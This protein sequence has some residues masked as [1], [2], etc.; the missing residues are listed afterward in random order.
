MAF[1]AN[2]P[3]PQPDLILS[4]KTSTLVA[5]KDDPS[6]FITTR[7]RITVRQKIMK[8]G[9]IVT[10]IGAIALSLSAWLACTKS[11]PGVFDA[12]VIASSIVFG[13]GVISCSKKNS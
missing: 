3:L 6:R 7:R 9:T 5:M 2:W 1:H 13:A 10:I 11:S 12:F 4:I 8:L